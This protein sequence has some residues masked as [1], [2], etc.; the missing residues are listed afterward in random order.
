MFNQK[1]MCAALAVVFAGGFGFA[2]Q[3]QQAQQQD[4]KVT[5]VE[6]VEV[7][8][9]N[10]R[11]TDA[12][13]AVPV[14]IITAEDIRR[15]G[16]QTITEVLRELPSAAA[17]GLTE[18][19]G[20]G[21]FSAG[22]ASVSLRGLGSSAT[23]VLLNGRRVAPYGLVDPNFGQS[24]AVNLNAIP[25]SVVERIEVLKD[26]ASAIYG[27]EAI[28]GV[29]NIILRRDYKGA[30][31][32]V[33]GSMNK[34]GKYGTGAV[35]ATFGFGDLTAN[36][37]NVFGN[38]EAYRQESVM[39]KDVQGF[40]NRDS[41]RNV[42]LTGVPSSSYHPALNYLAAGPGGT[43][44]FTPSTA[45]PTSDV[46]NAQAVLGGAARGTFCLYDQWRFVEI[47]P[48]SERNN[49]FVRGTV[50]LGSNFEGFAEG[51]FNTTNTYFIGPPRVVG[52][53]NGGTFNA[54][55][56]VLVPMVG[57]LP[58]G[59]PN[60]PFATPTFYRARMDALG[61]QDNEVDSDTARAVVGVK[62]A[63]FG[64]DVEAS[65][66]WN[67]NKTTSTNYNEVRLTEFNNA[68]TNGTLN[69]LNPSASTTSFA[70]L[71]AN[72]KDQARSSFEILSLKGSGELFALPGGK[73]ALAAGLEFRK[74]ERD[75]QP[76]RLKTVAGVFGR[77]VASAQGSRDVTTVYGEV[78]LPV[79]PTVELQVAAR[80]DDYSD[81]GNS[82]TPKIAGTWK[83]TNNFKLRASYAE[84][85]RA[86]SLTEITRSATSGFFNGVDDPRRCNRTQGITVGCGL[87]LPG[88]IVASPFLK[89]EEAESKT[90]GFVF[91]PTN[92][93]SLTVDYFTIKRENEITF[94][95][96]N[97]ILANEGSTDPRYANTVVRD[98]ANT[99]V[100]VPNDPGAIL[101]IRTG[102][103]NLG[104]TRVSGF[105]LNLRNR[106]SLGDWGRLTTNI[107]LTHYTKQEG[108]G[109]PTAPMVTFNGY[110]N[111]PNTRG[112]ARM[113]WEYGAWAN[114]LQVNYLKGFKPFGN[115]DQ[116]TGGGRTAILTCS[117][118]NGTYLGVCNV[119]DW[120]TLDVGTS[121]S[122]IKNLTLSATVRNIMDRKPSTDPLARPFNTAWYSPQGMNISLGASYRFW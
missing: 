114:S 74:E 25:L 107:D 118:P 64:W 99:S 91:E 31:V 72:L 57:V 101:F 86:P 93:T 7:T 70:S 29:V 16:R 97:E 58:V 83:A 108:S 56:G 15:S 13:T 106:A 18:L 82:T 75:V 10:I 67:E 87:S 113:T 11:R 48:K 78:V 55:T 73:A 12:E 98:P 53:G 96:L 40:L 59:N 49:A 34:D 66:L 100:T 24:A 19:T 43:T 117:N 39:F 4:P 69:F 26:G 62:G 54:T 47:V 35:T 38:V 81:F 5:K 9:S 92:T 22:A 89:P 116:A 42:Y 71:G 80:V 36:G 65:Y 85:F 30:E 2:A 14:Q 121:Y 33:R 119:Q 23:L 60:N 6:R 41:F 37:F 110:R 44:V 76:D 46:A 61:R 21:S 3:A 8:G 90:I 112:T 63:L 103:A 115:P 111:A 94:L 120:V 51:S 28:A 17:G 88:L 84:G 68:I 102:F 20:S 52:Q 79:L 1:H 77:G 95:S 105:D 32:A 27:S 50:A 104:K 109:T 122:G 45:C